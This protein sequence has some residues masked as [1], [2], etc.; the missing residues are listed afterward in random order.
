MYA[1]YTKIVR[2][3][4]KFCKRATQAIFDVQRE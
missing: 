2:V 3:F 4:G 1:C